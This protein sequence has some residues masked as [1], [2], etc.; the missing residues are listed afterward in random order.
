MVNLILHISSQGMTA[1]EK[2]RRELH[3]I[4]AFQDDDA[5]MEAFAS[6]LNTVGRIPVYIITDFIEEEFR[7]ASLPHV[8]GRD[9]V[10]LHQRHASRL[11]RSS[12]FRFSR[13]LDRQKAQRRDDNVLFSALANPELMERWL[14]CLLARKMPLAGIH[15]VA[16]LSE[17]LA[18]CLG[19]AKNKV[20][21]LAHNKNGGLRQSY[22]ERGKVRFSRLSPAPD[23]PPAHY[24]DYIRDEISKTQRYLGS[25]HFLAPDEILDVCIISGGAYL[26]GLESQ[27]NERHYHLKDAAQL[28]DKLGVRLADREAFCD[29]LFVSLLCKAGSRNVYAQARHRRYFHAY[30]L[31]TGLHAA[32]LAIAGGALL[33]SGIN[34]SDGL[35][36]R[37]QAMQSVNLSRQAQARYDV[38]ASR[39]PDIPVEAE[40]IAAAIRLAGFIREQRGRPAPLLMHISRGLGPY[41]GIR[42]NEIDWRSNMVMDAGQGDS[43]LQDDV[44]REVEESSAAAPYQRAIIKGEIEPF[45][46]NYLR[47]HRNIESFA[48][49]LRRDPGISEVEILS[50][51]LNVSQA[52]TVEGG[53]GGRQHANKAQFSVSIKMQRAHEKIL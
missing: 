3:E 46:G 45:D 4:G 47:A 40:N 49:V 22:M 19:C 28:A 41:A 21:L 25:L 23:L 6:Y 10:A 11:F 39:L 53:F 34:V 38:V 16:L 48:E 9:R 33:W 2:E 42:L 51:P 32:I 18:R 37:E 8:T 14:E 1:Y 29:R 50:L 36:Y 26:A 24:A 44:T 30:H 15:S 13:V 5:G 35:I 52:A 17:K 7:V 27:L 12:E 31:R 43:G 20:L